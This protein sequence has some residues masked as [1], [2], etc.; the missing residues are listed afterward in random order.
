MQRLKLGLLGASRIADKIVPLISSLDRLQIVG[1]AARSEDSARLFAVKHGL[2]K[3]F[4]T[5]DS[6][7]ADQSIDAVYI[8]VL[9]SDHATL[10]ERALLAGKHILCEKPLVLDGHEAQRLF[11]MARLRQL[12]LLEGL[13]YRFHPQIQKLL[14]FVNNGAVGQLQSVRAEFSFLLHDLSKPQ[15]RTTAAGGGGALN[16]LGCY[17]ID[18]I[19][20]IAACSG[21]KDILDVVA[22]QRRNNEIDLQTVATIY[23]DNGFE[24]SLSV[25]IDRVALNTWEV[26]G[27]AGSV[28]ALRFD[29]QGTAPAPL[30]LLNDDSEA[31]LLYCTPGNQFRDEFE[32]FVQTIAG[33]TAPFITASDS[34]RNAKLL[35]GIRQAAPHIK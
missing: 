3:T 34:V 27:T 8:S 21:A 19:S 30:Y 6:C 14:E 13:M 17:I 25:A 23:Y 33:E 18:F 24:A 29:P 12:V 31:Q 2:E 32:N 15:P 28:A 9:N 10:I 26:L 35:E 11:E 20:I 7:L 16:D 22:S 1:V 5:Y 4:P